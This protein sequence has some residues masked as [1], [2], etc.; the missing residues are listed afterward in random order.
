MTCIRCSADSCTTVAHSRCSAVK[1]VSKRSAVIPSTPFIGVRI[2]WLMRAR[3]SLLAWAAASAASRVL[4][5]L[6][7]VPAAGGDVGEEAGGAAVEREDAQL[8]H[9]AD[10]LD[11]EHDF[12]RRGR[13]P[14]VAGAARRRG[15][16]GGE[17]RQRRVEALAEHRVPADAGGALGGRVPRLDAP[18]GAED[19]HAL[20]D[21]RHDVAQPGVRALDGL[22]H[23]GPLHHAQDH[24]RQHLHHAEDADDADQGARRQRG[25]GIQPGL[26]AAVLAAFDGAE[27]RPHALE[28]GSALREV[29]RHGFRAAAL[30]DRGDDSGRGRPGKPSTS[31]PGTKR[32]RVRPRRH[33]S[34]RAG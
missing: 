25:H 13:P 5:Q 24:Q 8:E 4:Q 14:G 23:A 26:R 21:R 1:G 2:S 20:V 31:R 3:N 19:E 9:A 28:R 12:V 29:A 30:A 33:W 18:V 32:A 27:G 34:T 17:G 15:Q 7:F 6:R 22:E 16:S 11:L 10:A